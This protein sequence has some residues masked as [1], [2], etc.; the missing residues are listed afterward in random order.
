MNK[1]RFSLV[2]L[3]SVLSLSLYPVNAQEPPEFEAPVMG[4]PVMEEGI[5]FDDQIAEMPVGAPD[6]FALRMGHRMGPGMGMGHGCP[7][8]SG[9]NSLSDEQ[10]E[11]FY[12]IKN[13]MKD[14]MGPKMLEMSKLR[15]QFCDELNRETIDAKAV[16]K[17][18][19]RMAALK[20]EMSH[21]FT[22]SA[23]DAMNVLTPEQRKEMRKKMVQGGGMGGCSL[24]FKGRMMR[25][26]RRGGPGGPG[27]PGCPKGFDKPSGPSEHGPKADAGAMQE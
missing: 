13:K 22:G 25:H 4:A 23:V 7:F 15:R 14:E 19:D 12:A 1:A 5:A 6:T 21:L 8:L 24:G 17:L 11:K 18:S 16:A 3:A 2:A 27:A 10:Y 26:H 20:G 9:E